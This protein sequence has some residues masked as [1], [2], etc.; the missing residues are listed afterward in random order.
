MPHSNY[1]IFLS[2]YW[3][4]VRQVLTSSLV[5]F[6]I[7]EIPDKT[8]RDVLHEF[9]ERFDLCSARCWYLVWVHCTGLSLAPYLAVVL[10]FR[11]RCVLEYFI[12]GLFDHVKGPAS[13]KSFQIKPLL[14]GFRLNVVIREFCIFFSE[15]VVRYTLT[16]T[17]IMFLKN[18]GKFN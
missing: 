6:N 14:M 16:S 18:L 17:R 12:R 4:P 13:S 8:S 2:S 10:S 1:L 5:N 3:I 15:S 7:C 11:L 9:A